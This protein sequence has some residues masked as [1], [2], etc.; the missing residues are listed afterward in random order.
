MMQAEKDNNASANRVAFLIAAESYTAIAPRP[1]RFGPRPRH[2]PRQASLALGLPGLGLLHVPHRDRIEV[3]LAAVAAL[4][5]ARVVAAARRGL[6][7]HVD[8]GA[9]QVDDRRRALP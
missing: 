2:R 8:R 9:R 1:G 6:G 3:V 7:Q 5:V 4:G